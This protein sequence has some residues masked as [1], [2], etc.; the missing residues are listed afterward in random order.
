MDAHEVYRKKY[1]LKLVR[2]QHL[3]EGIVS[4]PQTSILPKALQNSIQ[5]T[6]LV[7]E[8]TAELTHKLMV[9]AKE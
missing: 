9:S 1:A 8:I 2:A 6:E 7:I 4:Q 5:G 3:L